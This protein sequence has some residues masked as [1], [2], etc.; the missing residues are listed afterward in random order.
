MTFALEVLGPAALKALAL[1]ALA[2]AVTRVA[3]RRSAALRHMVWLAALA[4]CV[5]LPL[6]EAGLPDGVRMDLRPAVGLVADGF[7]RIVQAVDPPAADAPAEAGEGGEPGAAGSAGAVPS[8]RERARG[9]VLGSTALRAA[10]SAAVLVWMAGGL[11]VLLRTVWGLLQLA[12]IRRRASPV[13]ESRDLPAACLDAVEPGDLPEIRVSPEVSLPVVQGLIRPT[14]LLP[15]EALDEWP[16]ERTSAVVLHEVGHVRRR[17]VASHLLTRLACALYWFNPFVWW[18]AREARREQERAC[19]DVVLRAGHRPSSYARHLLAIARDGVGSAAPAGLSMARWP[20]LEGRVLALLEE[21]ADRRPARRGSL[22][23]IGMPALVLVVSLATVTVGGPGERPGRTAASGE[24]GEVSPEAAVPAPDEEAPELDR[25]VAALESP[26][27]RVRK[28]AAHELGKR[29]AVDAIPAL[30][31]ILD[32]DPD[33]HVRKA[34]AW[35]IGE[36]ESPE[37]VRTLVDALERTPSG[38]LRRTVVEALGETE[39]AAAVPHLEE[40]LRQ[41]D[42]RMRWAALEALLENKTDRA[43]KLVHRAADGPD[44]ELRE[45]ARRLLEKERE[46]ERKKAHEAGS[47]ERESHESRGP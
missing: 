21:D 3:F 34:A 31:E 16:A 7:E 19:D 30:A 6:A 15:Q 11:F 5:A 23:V 14:L 43:R 42:R 12:G 17:D 25:L 35:A 27:A 41:D 22:A 18:A 26:S 44:R 24:P 2:W 39:Q 28:D 46:H 45:M 32:S 10:G 9:G 33:L 4:G 36:T 38:K 1:L 20:D 47:R 40:A 13:D 8:S 37:A 29:E